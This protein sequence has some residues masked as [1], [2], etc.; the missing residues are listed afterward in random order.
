[1]AVV[2]V[3]DLT[4]GPGVGFLPLVSLGPAFAGLIGTWR[5]TALIGVVALLLCVGLGVYDG[6]FD[7]RRGPTAMASVAGV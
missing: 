5:R 4:A 6:L 1:M 7:S 3:V 2:T